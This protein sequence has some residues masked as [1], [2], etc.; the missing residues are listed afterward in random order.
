MTKELKPKPA[1]RQLVDAAKK[2][3]VADFHSPD[4]KENDLAAGAN[5]GRDRKIRAAVIYALATGADPR[6]PVH[7]RGVRLRGARIVGDLDF[8]GTELARPLALLQCYMEKTLNLEGASAHSIF[9]TGSRV[10]KLKADGL[11][12]RYDLCLNGGFTTKA[13]ASLR[14]A[15]IQGLLDCRE[16]IFED[17]DGHALT[18][19]RVSVDGDALLS[20]GFTA[21]GQ[22]ELKGA[23]IRGNL[24]CERANFSNPEHDALDATRLIVGGSILGK[25]VQVTGAVR[26]T[27]SRITGNLE[28]SEGI[29]ENPG[30]T[31]LNL[32]V[33]T[34]GGDVSMR[35]GFKASGGVRLR[36]SEINGN[37]ECDGG[38]FENDNDV[39]I[40]ADRLRIKG[41]VL[42]RRKFRAVGEVRLRGAE[43]ESNLECDHGKFRNPGG[44][45]LNGDRVSIK[46]DV[47]LSNGF[48]ATGEVQLTSAKI[49]RNFDCSRGKFQTPGGTALNADRLAVGGDAFL[50]NRFKASG[51]VR[52]VDATIGSNLD[53]ENARLK[54]NK[55]TGISLNLEGATIS[56][57]LSL[58][59]LKIARNGVVDLSFVHVGELVDDE[60]GWP[61]RDGLRLD[62]LTYDIL[63]GPPDAKK[64]R[65]WLNRQPTGPF[66]PQPYEQLSRVLREM[67]HD[68]DAQKI[69]IAK[70][71]ALRESGE[72]GWLRWLWSWV[73][74]V[75]VRYGYHPSLI[76]VWLVPLVLIGSLVFWHADCL[77]LMTPTKEHVLFDRAT[78]KCSNGA[79]NL[80]DRYP[81]FQPIVYSL[82]VFFPVVD[83]QQKAYWQ[84]TEWPYRAF[85]WLHTIT[86]W[87]FTALA[88]A[89]VTRLVKRD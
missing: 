53:F 29:F 25:G 50:G 55:A 48:E 73:L 23:R 19:D 76:L 6:W 80:P 78:Y 72:L 81:R 67:G 51:E 3:V 62:G 56:R 63:A 68:R 5:W 75:T 35:N 89:G 10:G 30:K 70:Q 45:A 65:D 79:W 61:K 59:S 15:H 44:T 47:L 36:G 33:A 64:R 43:I 11:Q 4:G 85:F 18:A 13:G 28:F 1:E 38:L 83:L 86:G 71:V 77:C 24:E 82:D 31:A 49:G 52:L 88:V 22:V 57:S 14:G 32:I 42:F 74:A 34:I 17:S 46:G 40:S 87:L 69:A 20:D 26:L 66:R 21:N 41:S 54:R 84:P 16:S 60:S 7:A 27:N 39:A 8:A 58:R 2:G 9:L 37:L 12:T